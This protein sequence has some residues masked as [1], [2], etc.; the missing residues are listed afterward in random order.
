MFN[1]T[2]SSTLKVQTKLFWEKDQSVME[3]SLNEFLLTVT[4]L[5]DIKFNS[6]L[7]S[8]TALVIYK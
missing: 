8:W 2:V 5:I 3:N 1:P 6:D 7:E 4:E